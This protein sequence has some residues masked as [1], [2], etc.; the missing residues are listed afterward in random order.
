VFLNK[1]EDTVVWYA[2]ISCVYCL[3]LLAAYRDHTLLLRSRTR[4]T[5]LCVSMLL[6]TFFTCDVF[7]L[8]FFFGELSMSS[9]AYC[10][11]RNYQ[12]SMNSSKSKDSK[13]PCHFPEWRCLYQFVNRCSVPLLHLNVTVAWALGLEE[14]ISIYCS[15]DSYKILLTQRLCLHCTGQPPGLSDTHVRWGI[16]DLAFSP[17]RLRSQ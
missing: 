3:L 10:R 12:P 8:D 5:S 13:S 7:S 9:Q 17:Q 14:L 6:N 16:T 15:L 2:S 4:G 1:K 11:S